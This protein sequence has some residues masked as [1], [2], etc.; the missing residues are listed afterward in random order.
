MTFLILRPVVSE[1]DRFKINEPGMLV[2]RSILV[3]FHLALPHPTPQPF[4]SLPLMAP[5][6]W[7]ELPTCGK[8]F[9]EGYAK[10][11]RRSEIMPPLW[12]ILVATL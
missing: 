7:T 12:T 1:L 10:S 9:V 2:R 4:P 6:L 3:H 8:R 11:G 5:Y